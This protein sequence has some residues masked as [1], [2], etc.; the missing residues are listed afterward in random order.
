MTVMLN[1]QCKRS[2]RQQQPSLKSCCTISEGIRMLMLSFSALGVHNANDVKLSWR[3]QRKMKSA[4]TCAPRQV[5]RSS[6]VIWVNSFT[7]LKYFQFRNKIRIGFRTYWCN[8]CVFFLLQRRSQRT[9]AT[10]YGIT[11]IDVLSKHTWLS[12]TALAMVVHVPLKRNM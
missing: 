2:L 11:K 10:L 4:W 6:K 3:L 5:R 9:K 7:I 12:P 1:G 8:C